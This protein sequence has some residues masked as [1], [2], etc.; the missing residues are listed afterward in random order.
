MYALYFARPD[1]FTDPFE[2]R[3]S[4]GNALRHSKS[5][6]IFHNLYRIARPENWQ[7]VHETMRKVV[8]IS[9]WHR[10][11]R[12]SFQMWQAYTD[13]P[14]SVVI[15]SSVKALRRFVPDSIMKYAVKYA[16][17]DIPRT[18]FSHTSL[19]FYKPSRYGVEREYRLLRPPSADESFEF[20]NPADFF[21]R[22]PVKPKKI[23]HRVITHP[24]ATKEPKVYI[25]QI[26][27]RYLP[28]RKREDSALEI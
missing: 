4:L 16:P 17:L 23:I 1:R 12:E 14:A 8:F 2:G 10:N 21:R 15:T 26:L 18:E 19:F 28:C 13:S 20:E 22:I 25:E 7:Q 24:D 5:E 27:R 6:E 11:T 3:L 9:C